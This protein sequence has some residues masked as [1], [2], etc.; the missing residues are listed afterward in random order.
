MILKILRREQ[1]S[2]NNFRM[3]V[4]VILGNAGFVETGVYF[5]K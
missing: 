3:Y 2:T 4:P 1:S 5:T